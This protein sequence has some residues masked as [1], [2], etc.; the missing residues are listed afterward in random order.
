MV[1]GRTNGDVEGE[2]ACPLLY[3]KRCSRTVSL[4]SYSSPSGS[5]G[6]DAYSL[7]CRSWSPGAD[8][9]DCWIERVPG[10]IAS[11]ATA[12]RQPDR[13]AHGQM[14]YWTDTMNWAQGPLGRHACCRDEETISGRPLA[15]GKKKAGKRYPGEALLPTGFS[16]HP[17]Q[18][19][20]QTRAADGRKR[21]NGQT[22]VQAWQDLPFFF[23][24]KK[25]SWHGKKNYVK[26][27]YF[28]QSH[29][30]YCE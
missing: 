30:A 12:T 5:G 8:L 9:K 20:L 18:L 1:C 16:P 25:G 11:Q 26:L 7:F 27:R 24:L 10:L 21:D 2:Y 6:D 14:V 13:T 23:L 3:S 29:R 28:S 4:P 22:G 19:A 15:Q 17:H